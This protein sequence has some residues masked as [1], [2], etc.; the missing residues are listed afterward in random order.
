V[1]TD[2]GMGHKS[3]DNSRMNQQSPH[4]GR[5][6]DESWKTRPSTETT[7]D[8]GLNARVERE[9]KIA[10]NAPRRGDKRR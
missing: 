1:V 2:P 6:D 3:S 7:S 4:V 8:E 5:G 9:R 10:E